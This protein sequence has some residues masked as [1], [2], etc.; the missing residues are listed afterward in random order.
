MPKR[1]FKFRLYLSIFN[2]FKIETHFYTFILIHLNKKNKEE[3]DQ[4]D[5]IGGSCMPL[6]P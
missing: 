4:D 3:V 6:L 2:I 1:F 5:D